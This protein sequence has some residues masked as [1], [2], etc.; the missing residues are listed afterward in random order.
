[1]A[2]TE[3]ARGPGPLVVAAARGDLPD[4]AEA[5]EE[6]RAHMRRVAALL[7]EWA[8]ALGLPESERIRWTAAGWLHDVLREADPD[9]LRREVPPELRDL[10]DGL[11][12]GPAA[13]ERLASDADPD[14]LRAIRYHTIGHPDLDRLGRALYLADFLEPARK[15]EREWR[16][17]LRADMPERMDEVL[18]QVVA[19]RMEHLVGRNTGIRPE[20]AAFWS[21]IAGGSA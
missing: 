5:G 21:S 20:T 19:R 9:R 6:R 13:A 7:G 18:R 8:A 4:W 10:P 2:S 1:V 15:F 3:R 16:A 17:E 11:L 12:H 14:L